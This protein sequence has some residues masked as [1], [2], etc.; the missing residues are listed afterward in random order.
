VNLWYARHTLFVDPSG[1]VMA[2]SAARRKL[3]KKT[4]PVRMNAVFAAA[5]LP[6]RAV[7]FTVDCETFLQAGGAESLGAKA[8]QFQAILSELSREMGSSFPVYVLFTKADRIPYFRDFVENLTEAE[9]SEILGVTLPLV[10]GSGQGVYAEEQTRR[11]TEA[12]RELYYSLA[13]KRRAY[14]ARE[15]DAARLPNIYEFPRE[16]GKLRS[17]LTQFLVDL[18]R[19]S[20]LGASPFLR[21]FYFTGIRPVT[22]ADVTP[23]AQV[24]MAEHQPFDAGATQIFTRRPAFGGS[25]AEVQE[26]GSRR[27]PQWVFLRHLFPDVIL[28]DRPAGSLTQRNVKV[29]LAR[30]VLLGAVAA[31]GLLLCIWWIVSYS[32]N[33]RLIDDATEAA[34]SVPSVSLSAGQL[35]S[36][37]ALQRLTRVKNTL[38][39][40]DGY[41][42]NGVPFGYDA[43]LYAGNTIREPLQTTYYAD[44]RR[45][46]LTPVQQTLTTICGKPDA[47]DSQ[48][49]R[50]VYDALKAYLITTDHHEKS[51]PEFLTPVL[52][53]HWQQDQQVDTQRQDLARQ[54]FD[55]YASRLADRNPY[56][57]FASPD[58]NAVDAARAYL[59]RLPPEERIYQAMLVAAGNGAKPIIFN[60]DFPG[61]RATIINSYKV[62]PAFTKN[63]Y[64][65]FAK[66]LKDPEKYLYGET[67]VL[68]EQALGSFDR[69]TMLAHVTSRYNQEFEKAWRAYLSATAVVPYSSVPDAANKLQQIVSPQS[70]LLEVF[71]V[72]SDNTAANKQL[73]AQAFQPVQSVTPP[74]CFDKPLVGPGNS[75]YMQT[76]S[77]LQGA[78]QAV[79]PI[80]RADTNNVTT[81][82]TAATQALNAANALGF[83]F[84]PDPN[85]PK[86]TV[87]SKT[88]EI[89]R[90]PITRVPPLLKGAG[91][92]PVNAAAGNVCASIAPMLKKYPFNPRSTIDATLEEVN[93][94]LRPNDGRLWQLYNTSLKQYLIPSGGEYVA[95]SGQQLSITLAFQNFFNRAARMSQAFY[96]AN[97]AQPNLTFSMQVLPSQDV[98]HL[99]LTIDGQT[100]STDLKSGPRSQTFSWPGS[101]QGVSLGVGFAGGGE[102]TIV[103]TSGLWAIWHFLDS[104]ERMQSSGNQLQLEWIER[105][106]AGQITTINGHPAAVRFALDAQSSQVFRQQYFS[107][108]V[109]TSKAVQ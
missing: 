55:F 65:N 36:V 1:A 96:G 95:A 52:V 59:N 26:A 12:F 27:I 61:S 67:W 19:P 35:A 83:S 98:T 104:G 101:T 69:S 4:L 92:G 106:S 29:N 97:P 79:G 62:D 48:G 8:R 56:P 76:L 5:S 6:S 13:D 50:Y 23:A 72:A 43:F 32:N 24:P 49:Y 39:V 7:V 40:L 53:Q 107:G 108:L 88:T 74:G 80:D 103:Q 66:Q 15:H 38:A 81:A 14:L 51:T 70:P 82:N 2:S 9:A 21:G 75:G 34:R 94:F 71:C 99:T 31:A 68:G 102:L 58:V 16:F 89:L 22:V 44:F 60:V 78:L 45:L 11:V 100:L 25:A 42:R 86:T 18:C 3:F 73:A 77:A 90:E 64:A 28:A 30:R 84:A 10:P 109:C 57:K 47:Y 93:D 41:A 37:E 46:L 54:N 33:S 63:G 105:S 87:L 20:Q 91:A 85:D 17:L